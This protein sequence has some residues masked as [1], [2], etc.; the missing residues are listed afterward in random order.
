[1]RL[2]AA[3]WFSWFLNVTV[4]RGQQN[5]RSQSTALQHSTLEQ[6]AAQ[7]LVSVESDPGLIWWSD[8]RGPVRSSAQGGLALHLT[9]L[10]R[11]TYNVA[12][13]TK[14]SLPLLGSLP[15]LLTADWLTAGGCRWYRVAIL[16]ARPLHSTPRPVHSNLFALSRARKVPGCYDFTKRRRCRICGYQHTSW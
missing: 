14:H 6:T 4:D 12:A 2:T 1:M 8:P 5:R 7:L 3:R 10:L 13:A 11:H 9:S 15:P 16:K